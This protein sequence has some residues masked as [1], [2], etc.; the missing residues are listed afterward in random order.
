MKPKHVLLWINTLVIL[1]IHQEKP[2][3]KK[4]HNYFFHFYLSSKRN[5]ET[6]MTTLVVYL[7]D[8]VI[9]KKINKVWKVNAPTHVRPSAENWYPSRHS[10]LK[11][12]GWLL[13]TALLPHTV[14]WSR[15]SST[16]AYRNNVI[17]AGLLKQLLKNGIYLFKTFVCHPNLYVFPSKYVSQGGDQNIKTEFK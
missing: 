5:E 10:H 14:G 13:Q 11:V 7:E 4:K 6:K 17:S 8:P 9:P 15:H 3:L 1:D 16:S 12:P 2:R